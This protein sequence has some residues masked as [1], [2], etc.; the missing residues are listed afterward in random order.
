MG[1]TAAAH[2]LGNFTIDT[3]AGIVL[4]V[5]RVSID[6]VVDMAEIPTFQ[7]R[8][9]IDSDGDGALSSDET[10]TYAA[11]ACRTLARGLALRVD[12]RTTAIDP[13][14]ASVRLLEGQADLSTLRLSCRFEAA[15]LA[16]VLSRP[17]VP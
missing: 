4:G 17:P 6:Y 15:T 11:K 3:S 9:R 12:R 14:T 10:S 2:P 5:D 7:E 8:P 1:S 16:G 13:R